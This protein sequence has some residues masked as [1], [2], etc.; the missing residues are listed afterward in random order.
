MGQHNRRPFCRPPLPHEDTCSVARLGPSAMRRPYA[1]GRIAPCGM[2][3]CR[4]G[5]PGD[6]GRDDLSAIQVELLLAG[7]AGHATLTSRVRRSARASTSAMTATATAWPA[8][9]VNPSAL[10]VRMLPSRSAALAMAQTAF[11]PMMAHTIPG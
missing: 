6:S 2:T 4:G 5:F 8:T 3:C 10:G 11:A 1:S 7:G 9:K